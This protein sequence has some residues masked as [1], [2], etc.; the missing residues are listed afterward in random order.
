MEKEK[1][2]CKIKKLLQLAQRGIGG[3]REK[4][5]VLLEKLCRLYNINV[6]ELD[7]EKQVPHALV[8]P[9]DYNV[10]LLRQIVACRR[11]GTLSEI[12][13]K[14]IKKAKDRKILDEVYGVKGWNVLVTSTESDF[15]QL[16]YEYEIYKSEFY[17]DLEALQYAFYDRN[18]LLPPASDD[19]PES[20]MTEERKKMIQKALNFSLGI[21]KTQIHQGIEKK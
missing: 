13:V 20:E 19:D 11:T 6:E 9:E 7:E 17:K 1:S 8:I 14:K 2:R 15:V 21:N 5:R 12:D 10:S 18:D 3:E 4:A 16:M